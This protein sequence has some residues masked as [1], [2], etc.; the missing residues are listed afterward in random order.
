MMPNV[1]TQQKQAAQAAQKERIRRERARRNLVDFSCYID[2]A[3]AHNY[4]AKHLQ[5]VANKY[6]A[7]LEGEFKRLMILMPN[8]HWKSSVGSMKFPAFALGKWYEDDEPH[9]IMIISHTN[10]KA[11]EFSAYTRNLVRDVDDH[12]NSRYKNIFPHI[13]ISRTRQSSEKWGLL[14]KEGREESFPT[15]LAGSILAPPT[16]D[17]ARLIVVDDLIKKPEDAQ[18]VTYLKKITASWDI[19]VMSRLNNPDAL[20][21]FNNTRWSPLDLPGVLIK[22]MIRDMLADQ[23]HLVLLPALAYTEKERIAARRMGVPVNDEDPIG[24]K[25][26]EALWPALFPSSWHHK[27]KANNPKS[28]SAIGQQLPVPEEGNLISRDNFKR[29]AVPPKKDIVWLI[30]TDWAVDEK[31][32]AKDDPDFQVAG[33]LGIWTPDGDKQNANIVIASLVR[34]Q[35]G[36]N[37]GK[38]MLRHFAKA[39]FGLLKQRPTIWAPPAN[40][41]TVILNDLRGHQDLLTWRIRSLKDPR[42]KAQLGSYSKDKVTMSGPWRDRAEAG[43][44]YIVDEHWSQYALVKAFPATDR[45]RLLGDEPLAWHEKLFTEIEAFPEYS[46]DDMVDMISVGTHAGGLSVE[47]KQVQVIKKPAGWYS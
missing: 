45:K 41:D 12:G 32:V 46:H 19:G 21:V 36:S 30:P 8:R 17:G 5:F 3:Q 37:A 20:I 2:P 27:Q 42:A 10:T 11:A 23:W 15:M 33:L 40:I 47:K 22:R 29:L 16:G 31:Q 24:R 25:P 34:T 38:E 43:R 7:L 4:R 35:M 9:Q 39:M 44:V 26:G 14:D 1:A 18:S 13:R 28:F 6:Q